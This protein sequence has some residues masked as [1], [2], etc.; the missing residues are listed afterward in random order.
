M[1]QP[2]RQRS[3]LTLQIGIQYGNGGEGRV[4]A[5]LFKFLPS[6]GFDVIGAVAGPDDVAELTGGKIVSFSPENGPKLSRFRSARTLL[7]RLLREQK[8]DVV[9]FHFALYALPALEKLRFHSIVSHFHGPWGAESAQDGAGRVASTVRSLV[10]KTMYRQADRV[11]VLSK[12]FAELATVRYG[13]RPEL[14]RIVPGCVDIDRFAP[15]VSRTE[16]RQ[17]LGLPLD[18]PILFSIRRLVGRMGLSELI[19]AI[20]LIKEK[21]P[22]ILLC[23]GGRGLL[24]EALEEQVA[25]LGLA[26]HVRF[27]GFVDDDD[28]PFFYRA[29][30]LNIVPTLALEGFGL[31]A[32]ESLAAGTPSLVTNVGG[33]PEVVADLSPA[34]IIASASPEELAERIVS[35]LLGHT[36]LP[37]SE[38]C[39]AYAKERF[40]STLMAARTAAVYREI[41]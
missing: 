29:A 41:L 35:V 18:R 6:A 3:P 8:P 22:E 10:E 25:E 27:L 36:S 15:T 5:E 24:R 39:A 12:A 13:I 34:L 21:V 16:A 14:I 38:A 40:N 2:T 9:A 32:A 7:T 33:L 30:D 20:N 17:R 37:G 28:L 4:I 11:I 26:D 31:V 23:I 1:T 19:S